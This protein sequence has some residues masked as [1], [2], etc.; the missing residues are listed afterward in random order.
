MAIPI[1]Y[2]THNLLC[3]FE[4]LFPVSQ[5][6][7]GSYSDTGNNFGVLFTSI[8]ITALISPFESCIYLP[9]NFLRFLPS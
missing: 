8:P 7:F 3:H 9:A 6:Y 4:Y 2:L 1:I 5:T